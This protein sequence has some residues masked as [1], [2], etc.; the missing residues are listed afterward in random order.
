M[1]HTRQHLLHVDFALLEQVT[2]PLAVFQFDH[3][4]QAE[5]E[6]REM[7]TVLQLMGQVC[8]AD[9]VSDDRMCCKL[10]QV[11]LHQWDFF[12]NLGTLVQHTQKGLLKKHVKY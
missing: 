1:G 6:K 12:F 9:Q 10:C 11:R 5:Q 8:D 2:Q 7:C 4:L 3:L